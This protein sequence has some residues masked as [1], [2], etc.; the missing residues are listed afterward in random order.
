MLEQL[1]LPNPVCI[2]QTFVQLLSCQK[3]TPTW[4]LCILTR[5][6]VKY[7]PCTS[8]QNSNLKFMCHGMLVWHEWRA[9]YSPSPETI[10]MSSLWFMQHCA[11]S[12]TQFFPIFSHP[13]FLSR[14][15]RRRNGSPGA[16]CSQDVLLH[17]CT[18]MGQLL[19]SLV[20]K[21]LVLPSNSEGLWNQFW[22]VSKL[23][24]MEP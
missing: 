20:P 8:P 1:T 4:F 22:T 17:T 10:C 7:V 16:Q 23:F 24:L 5:K 14:H 21:V 9:L 18:Q 11:W 3:T 2:S 12:L 13:F 19:E 15:Q 6:Q